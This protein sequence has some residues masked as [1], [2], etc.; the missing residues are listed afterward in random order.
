M[1]IHKLNMQFCNI[2]NNFRKILD[3]FA[4]PDPRRNFEK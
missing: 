3:G 1:V 4:I 2:E